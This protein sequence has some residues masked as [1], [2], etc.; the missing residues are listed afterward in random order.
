MVQNRFQAVFLL[1]FPPQ[2]RTVFVPRT[3]GFQTKNI[4]F[5]DGNRKRET[6][7]KIIEPSL[8]VKCILSS[9]ISQLE[10]HQVQGFGSTCES[11]V[12]P[13]VIVGSKH[14]FGY[15]ALVDENPLPLPAL[16]FVAGHSVGIL[17]LQGV[18]PRVCL[19][20]LHP[21]ALGRDVLII[22]KHGVEKAITL[23]F[24]EC[25]RIGMKRI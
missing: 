11:S 20:L 1:R 8:E 7:A 17:H 21:F 10:I 13:S 25:G 16:R 24:S 12:E 9:L 5:W 15:I 14:I 6:S 3:Y 4:R 23:L 2:N 19:H 22:L 18:V